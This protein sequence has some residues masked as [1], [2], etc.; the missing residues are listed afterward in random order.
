MLATSHSGRT[1]V[2][3]NDFEWKIIKAE[4]V[5]SIES[6]EDRRRQ[7]DSMADIYAYVPSKERICG[8][9]FVN[10]KDLPPGQKLLTCA[11]CKEMCYINREAQLAAWPVHKKV[12]CPI[13]RDSPLLQERPE[14]F[15]ACLERIGGIIL[16]EYPV[17]VGES[18]VLL[19]YLQQTKVYF[20]ENPQLFAAREA[21]VLQEIVHY[22]LPALA[23]LQR[24]GDLVQVSRWWSI[25]GF[26]NYMLSDEVFLSKVM[27]ERKLQG[28]PALTKD[29]SES[30]K[31][32]IF[33][34]EQD[35]QRLA[36]KKPGM[37]LPPAYCGILETIF[38]ASAKIETNSRSVG[39]LPLNRAITKALI[40]MWKS[41]YGR[42]SY[43]SLRMS[44]TDGKTPWRTRNSVICELL[45]KA[46]RNEAFYYKSLAVGEVVP[47]LAAPQLQRLVA[48]D[49][50]FLDSLDSPKAAFLSHMFFMNLLGEELGQIGDENN[51][52]LKNLSTDDRL[53]L[54]EFYFKRW[55]AFSPLLN[56]AN[57]ETLITLFKILVIG[58]NQSNIVLKLYDRM[59][60][61]QPVRS[62]VKELIETNRLTILQEVR[63]QVDTYVSIVEKQHLRLTSLRQAEEAQHF[64]EDIIQLICEFSLP[65]RTTLE[66]N[67]D[68]LQGDRRKKIMANA[69]KNNN[70][71]S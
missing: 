39:D 50:S 16:G 38:S 23:S 49:E 10:E 57:A 67:L 53:E 30:G 17:R 56:S 43:A 55:G 1:D 14:S 11:K 63:P 9:T 27:R 8:Y 60:A 62:D 25:P 46:Q 15:S 71:R 24:E 61:L 65:E 66:A 20:E 19:Y 13:E 2:Y 34:T 48:E 68:R 33:D 47:G 51:R 7:E 54:L 42:V 41:P 32:I 31:Y 70:G 69:G 58:G 64:P 18:R 40:S 35:V 37:I 12:C 5:I 29:E 45:M 28:M 44:T 26:A 36:K 52:A 6:R 22:L 3:V 21:P 4:S 59:N